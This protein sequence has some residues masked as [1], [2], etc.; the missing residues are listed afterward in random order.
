[1]NRITKQ[2]NTLI[3][4][5]SRLVIVAFIV[6]TV[7]FLVGATQIST[8][9]GTSQ[10]TEDIPSQEALE[11][12]NEEFSSRTLT[13]ASA[14]STIIIHQR[15]NALSKSSL[16]E[17]ARFEERISDEEDLRAESFSSISSAVAESLDESA[18]TAEDRVRV[19]EKATQTEIKTA[20]LNAIEDRGLE[21]RI[22]DDYNEESV[23]ATGTISTIQHSSRASTGS[24]SS[25]GPGVG[26]NPPI[27]DIQLEIQ[28]IAGESYDSIIVFGTGIQSAELG[29]VS[30]DSL[31]IVIPVAITLIVVF[32]T[33]AYRD[34]FDIGLALVSLIMN[35]IWT[36]GFMGIAGIPFSQILVSVPPLLLAVGIDFGIH[37]INR[38]REEIDDYEPREAM[39]RSNNQLI[40]AFGIV[41]GSTTIGFGS[42]LSSPLGPIR[43]FG[44][45]AAVGILFTFVIFGVFLPALKLE[46]DAIRSKY[47]IP[48]FSSEPLGEDESILGKTLVISAYISERIP[49]TFVILLVI[50][51]LI[52]GGYGAG[53]SSEFSND[54]FLPPENLPAYVDFFPVEVDEYQTP[55]TTNLIEEDFSSYGQSSIILYVS[56][57]LRKDS[58]L[59]SIERLNND[60]PESVVQE[61]REGDMQSIVSIIEQSKRNPEF[62]ELVDENDVNNDGIP[63][64]NLDRI[65]NKLEE[66]NPQTDR[67]ITDTRGSTRILL[68]V[69]EDAKN[70][71]VK[72]AGESISSDSR[73]D[74]TPT[75][76]AVILRDVSSFIVDSTIN[77]VIIALVGTTIYLAAVYRRTDGK[78]VYGLI[79][80][81]PV[82]ATISALAATM[83]F[84]DIA[85]NPITATT[86]S[87]TI[88]IGVDYTIHMMHRITDEVDDGEDVKDAVRK[89]V[90]G[91]GG[92]LFGS[93]ATTAFGIGSLA[94]A[95]TPLL[96][97]FGLIIATGIIYS[98]IFS[99]LM[100]PSLFVIYH[101]QFE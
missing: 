67:F 17:I 91:T 74:I 87:I 41:A 80:M 39:K 21:N 4:E 65:Y 37:S 55:T 3:S 13:E 57:N 10:F 56:D 49:K 47:S 95:I 29:S 19:L 72:Q 22:S 27:Q 60:P 23:S 15:R 94:L 99:I 66:V 58:S 5:R 64:Q 52:L 33:V 24:S 2:V 90:K 93:M 36:F 9:S 51:S 92:A 18:R 59:Q 69:K 11:S 54:L 1:M 79:N 101:N 82:F 53:V 68:T 86:L 62:A 96:G 14:G 38:Y 63:D 98:F 28:N 46:T 76:E 40:I 8:D 81:V 78:A 73:L 42:N 20:V 61:D 35:V 48:E 31:S 45:V 16:L 100:L 89:S 97:Q 34:P 75:G 77:S 70:V 85:L 6:L 32:L 12:I 26:Q 25:G 7:F 83:R 44:I 88:G 43:E 71:D 30:Q 50:I 84:L